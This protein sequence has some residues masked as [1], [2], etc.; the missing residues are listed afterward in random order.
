MGNDNPIQNDKL[1]REAY[2]AGRRSAL[3]EQMGG[4]ASMQRMPMTG[5]G[6]GMGMGM[7]RGMG[8]RVDT[9]RPG[10]S[11]FVPPTPPANTAPDGKQ[12]SY[13]VYVDS[14]GRAWYWDGSTGTWVLNPYNP[15]PWPNPPF[16][17]YGWPN[18]SGGGGQVG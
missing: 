8:T 7:G 11:S 4:G 5:M 13:D 6:K 3:K 15:N 12:G 18:G 1:L 14:G 16:R 10:M 2:Q 9:N 17:P